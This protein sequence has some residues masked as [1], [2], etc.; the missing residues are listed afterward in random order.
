[1][2]HIDNCHIWLL[3]LLLI[4]Y[5]FTDAYHNTINCMRIC[6]RLTHDY[7]ENHGERSEKTYSVIK[8][9]GKE[10]CNIRHS[11]HGNKKLW[12]LSFSVFKQFCLFRHLNQ[13][14][15]CYTIKVPTPIF[16]VSKSI[17]LCH[18]DSLTTEFKTG[19]PMKSTY[20]FSKLFNSRRFGNGQWKVNFKEKIKTI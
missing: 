6:R 10:R 2:Q 14:F 5:L 13:S 18:A 17:L 11:F 7:N 16:A 20:T 4:L 9:K 15:S 19:P 12:N 1:M 8:G 3:T